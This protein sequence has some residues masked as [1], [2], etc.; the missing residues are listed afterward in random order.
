MIKRFAVFS[1]MLSG[2]ALSGSLAEAACD[3]NQ[4]IAKMAKLSEALGQRAAEAKTAQDSQKVIDANKKVTDAASFYQKQDY[5]AA[6]D[7]Y[8]KIANE[9]N[10][11][12]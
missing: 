9:N 2:I 12:L 5:S 7:A 8:D 4:A 11:K 3:M 6:C 1:V 10:I